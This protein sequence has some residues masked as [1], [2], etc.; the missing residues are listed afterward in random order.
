MIHDIKLFPVATAK[1][2]YAGYL[3][4]SGLNCLERSS[5]VF[6]SMLRGPHLPGVKYIRL[7]FE[8]D[9][10]PQFLCYIQEDGP[11]PFMCS[12]ER[13]STLVSEDIDVQMLTVGSTCFRE[14][15]ILLM[16][17]C[18]SLFYLYDEAMRNLREEGLERH[19][20]WAKAKGLCEQ[21][22][23]PWCDG[24]CECHPHSVPVE[25]LVNWLDVITNMHLMNEYEDQLIG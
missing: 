7:T 18:L 5:Y 14:E 21:C 4:L 3:A 10:E 2:K 24:I 16:N 1:R 13:P 12:L 25:L 17:A 20:V 19:E 15:P 22:Q 11:R 6:D 23:R 8:H 9:L